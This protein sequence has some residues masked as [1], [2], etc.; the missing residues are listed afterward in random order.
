M[1]IKNNIINYL[2]DKYYIVCLY[3]NYIYF[4]NYECLDRFTRENI[5]IKIKSKILNIKGDDLTII[6]ITKSDLL[7]R[8]TIDSIEMKFTNE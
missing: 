7:V 5:K 4:F 6:R 3:D 8:G 2:Y 1:N